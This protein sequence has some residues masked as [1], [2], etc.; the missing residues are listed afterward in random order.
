MIVQH[1]SGTT[2][3]LSSLLLAQ[4]RLKRSSPDRSAKASDGD[5]QRSPSMHQPFFTP[6]YTL[7]GVPAHSKNTPCS[8][9]SANIEIPQKTHTDNHILGYQMTDRDTGTVLYGESCTGKTRGIRLLHPISSAVWAYFTVWRS[10]K[11]VLFQLI[12]FWL[13]VSMGIFVL[14]Y[15]YNRL[16]GSEKVELVSEGQGMRFLNDPCK[17]VDGIYVRRVENEARVILPADATRTQDGEANHHFRFHISNL[18]KF[19]KG[20]LHL[21]D[22]EDPVP[23]AVFS[24][25]NAAADISAPDD[26]SDLNGQDTPSPRPVYYSYEVT[27]PWVPIL[28]LGLVP[29]FSVIQSKFRFLRWSAL[30]KGFPFGKDPAEAN[31][32]IL[33]EK[34]HTKFKDIAGM[35]EPK[36]EVMEVVDFLLHPTKYHRM[37][38]SVPKGIM[39]SGDPGVGKTLL[40]KAVAGEAR[41]NFIACTGSEFVEIFVGVGA[42]RVREL[43]ATARKSAPCVVFIDEIDAFARSR[44]MGEKSTGGSQGEGD[45]TVN[46]LLSELDGFHP[47]LG[48]VVIAGTNRLDVIDEALLR[49]GRFDRKIHVDLPSY[50]D[51]VKIFQ[52]H[53]APLKLAHS[54]QDGIE[55]LA[56]QLAA[57]TPGNSGADIKSICN[58]SAIIAARGGKTVVDMESISKGLDRVQIG[59][60]RESKVLTPEERERAAYHEAGHAVV[61]WH[62]AYADPICHLSIVQYTG[63]KMSHNQKLPSDK[64]IYLQVELDDRLCDMFGGAVAED[65]FL[66]ECTSSAAEDAHRATSFAYNY[67][68]KYGLC[69]QSTGHFSFPDSEGGV[70]IQKPYGSALE[71]KIDE[72]VK[73][74]ITKCKDRAREILKANE[75]AVLAV[76][77]LLKKYET[78][79][80]VDLTN[81]LGPRKVISQEFSTY[82][83][84]S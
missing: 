25:D 62:L 82:L 10:P 50:H 60:K 17:D 35:A 63:K 18:L 61:N 1:Y 23:R 28:L 22:A 54:S 33:S 67:V 44:K 69:P 47:T 55:S 13:R 48:V 8:A 11:R 46:A 2:R 84:S 34:I 58:E 4:K 14:K 32:S 20:L 39:L 71:K 78:V 51:R 40:A 57:R 7:P 21:P 30:Q 38:A 65:L 76:Y 77:G 52:L 45:N 43:F 26:R 12:L 74:V 75:H 29:L 81:L 5:S 56:N 83:G 3:L 66:K 42:S 64:F 27:F 79:S 19:E 6:Y 31:F 16:F 49:P 59:L 37:G 24:A 15:V 70:T 36:Q 53:L 73:L 41:V 80:A 9:Q 68:T 72:T